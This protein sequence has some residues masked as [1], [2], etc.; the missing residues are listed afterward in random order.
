MGTEL[1]PTL[2]ECLP[3]THWGLL[4]DT[5]HENSVNYILQVP[6]THRPDLSNK[7]QF[8]PTGLFYGGNLPLSDN[9]HASIH[10]LCSFFSHRQTN[11]GAWPAS[12]PVG[13]RD[14]ISLGV[15]LQ[16]CQADKS[17]PYSAE[18]KKGGAIPPIPS[19][20]SCLATDS[21]KMHNQIS[22]SD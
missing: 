2:Y 10:P 6:N 16:G 4:Q 12:C 15:K 5:V 21:V 13:T 1:Y 8:I 7:S 3:T 18:V 20:P 9:S 17:P 14:P 22:T 19:M 11:Y